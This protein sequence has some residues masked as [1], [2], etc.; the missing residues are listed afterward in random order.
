MSHTAGILKMAA[1]PVPAG[2]ISQFQIS[3]PHIRGTCVSINFW[4]YP[5]RNTIAIYELHCKLSG[6]LDI[7][8]AIDQTT[9]KINTL[10]TGSFKLFKRPFP[11]F[12]QF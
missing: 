5:K 4:K 3:S 2:A 8:C 12:K 6:K 1:F 7:V 11:G 10:R 9:Y